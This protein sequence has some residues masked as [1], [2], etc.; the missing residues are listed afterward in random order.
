MA[1]RE[2]KA[3]MQRAQDA[4][5]L[6][7]LSLEERMR[8]L[9]DSPIGREQLVARRAAI[10]EQRT[11][12]VAKKRRAE[13]AAEREFPTLVRELQ[14]RRAA[15]EAQAAALRTAEQAALDTDLAMRHYDMKLRHTVAGCDYELE[16]LAPKEID[17]F[18]TRCER[19]AERLRT[20]GQFAGATYEQ[21]NELLERL[22]RA[23]REAAA[24]KLTDLDGEELRAA[25]ERIE[26]EIP[27]DAAL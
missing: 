14:E 24:L 23:G 25:L 3:A 18:I 16:S 26:S 21:T 20:R 6:G 17:E 22:G 5:E 8:L 27:R 19:T 11:N 4:A 2:I 15:V 9:L 13:A 10:K 12:L 1:K 7:N